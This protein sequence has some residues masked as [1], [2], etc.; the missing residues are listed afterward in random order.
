MNLT[1]RLRLEQRVGGLAACIVCCACCFGQS[2]PGAASHEE[3]PSA[4][5]ISA[6]RARLQARLDAAWKR[7][8]ERAVEAA[9]RDAW[10]VDAAWARDASWKMITGPSLW[11]SV[12]VAMIV[13]HGSPEHLADAAR[14]LDAAQYPDERRRLVRSL[15]SKDPEKAPALIEPFLRD[16]DRRMQIAAVQALSDFDHPRCFEPLVNRLPNEMP[17]YRSSWSGDDRAM[18]DFAVAAAVRSLTNLRPMTGSEVKRWWDRNKGSRLE[19]APDPEPRGDG[20]PKGNSRGMDFFA[21][22]SFDIYLHVRG[23]TAPMP[24]GP[25]GWENLKDLVEEASRFACVSAEQVFG[26]VH[27]PVVRLLLCDETQFSAKA[28]MT[29]FAG[30]S[31]GNEI[32]IRLG[33]PLSMRGV[34]AHEMIHII[35]SANYNDQPRWL[36]EGLAESLTA[37]SRASSWSTGSV[38]ERGL[39]SILRQGAVSQIIQWRSGG[40]SGE[41]EQRNYELGHLVVDYLR[42]GGFAAPEVKLAALMGRLERS[43]SAAQALEQVYGLS[44]RDMDRDLVR[45]LDEGSR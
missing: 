34:I 7:G 20:P 15:G 17:A 10:G 26:P 43:M 35:H 11:R 19:R 6:E 38:R 45:W 22:P 12:G 29:S 28:G 44:P 1:I 41:R 2:S 25:L 42:F 8:D 24:D 16:R 5:E 39:E 33:H 31:N 3:V 27:L 13:E 21:T 37:S 23:M 32:V 36:S 14:S 9:L 30:V 40:V 18:M 4:K